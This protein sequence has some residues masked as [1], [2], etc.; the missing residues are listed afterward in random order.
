MFL[1]SYFNPRALPDFPP[2]HFI[3]LNIAIKTGFDKGS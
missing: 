3:T 2:S 1:T